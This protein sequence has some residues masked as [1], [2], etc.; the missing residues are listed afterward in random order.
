MAKHSHEQ[1]ERTKDR[2]DK[3]DLLGVKRQSPPGGWEML[4]FSGADALCFITLPPQFDDESNYYRPDHAGTR[5][6]LLGNIQTIG[7]NTQRPKLQ[8]RQ[9]FSTEIAGYSRGIR[10]VAGQAI[11]NVFDASAVWDVYKAW[12][13]D[14]SDDAVD[15]GNLLDELPTANIVLAVENESGHKALMKF[16]DVEFTNETMTISVNNVLTEQTVEF[17]ATYIDG[18]KDIDSFLN[19]TSR[20][21]LPNSYD[22]HEIA[23]TT[24][25]P[26]EDRPSSTGS[27]DKRQP[28]ETE[29]SGKVKTY[30]QNNNIDCSNLSWRS[31]YVPVDDNTSPLASRNSADSGNSVKNRI[32]R[33]DGSLSRFEIDSDGNVVEVEMQLGKDAEVDEHISDEVCNNG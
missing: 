3:S 18:L 2:Q 13:G 29:Y 16:H 6:F 14:L 15:I 1:F 26:S 4:S 17:V 9:L 20:S 10:T 32:V 7:Y 12:F 11:F 25:D 27:V 19:I 24:D 31:V 5:F 21:T 23:D 30:I 28:M 8:H 22:S 33:D